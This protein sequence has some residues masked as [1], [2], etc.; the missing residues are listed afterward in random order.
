M[1][2]ITS[3]F[4]FIILLGF[5]IVIIYK[6]SKIKDKNETTGNG[7]GIVTGDEPNP[8]DNQTT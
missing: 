5:I 8:N 6:I 1:F 7:G 4:L 3:L 2:N